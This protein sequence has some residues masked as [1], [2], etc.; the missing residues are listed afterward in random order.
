MTGSSE[1]SPQRI[2]RTRSWAG[3]EK[4][5]CQQPGACRAV[6]RKEREDG[7]R[8]SRSFEEILRAKTHTALGVVESLFRLGRRTSNIYRR[9]EED[10][11]DILIL[12]RDEGDRQDD[13]GQRQGRRGN[14]LGQSCAQDASNLCQQTAADRAYKLRRAQAE[15]A[16]RQSRC[17]NPASH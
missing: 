17:G 14:S 5:D 8:S 9:V 4:T 13:T 2:V 3:R 7:R 12:S 10:S 6:C 1:L 11:A 15:V 16:S